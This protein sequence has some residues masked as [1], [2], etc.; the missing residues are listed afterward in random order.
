MAP[1][2]RGGSISKSGQPIAKEL[3]IASKPNSQKTI[4][5]QEKRA[6]AASDGAGPPEPFKFEF[7]PSQFLKETKE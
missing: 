4:A 7:D 3:V 1:A 5:P 6:A 2:D